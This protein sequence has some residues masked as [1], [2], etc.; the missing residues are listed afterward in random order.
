MLNAQT[1]VVSRPDGRDDLSY[2]PTLTLGDY[3]REVVDGHPLLR[4]VLDFDRSGTR[5]ALEVL[6]ATVTEF[7]TDETGR[8]DSYRLA[9]RD[10]S[11][12]WIGTRQLLGL[13]TGS[14]PADAA[15][16]L[17]ILGGDGLLSRAITQHAEAETAGITLVTGDISA[18]MIVHALAQ[19]LP[20]V[21]QAAEFLF[22]RDESVDAALLA[23]GTHHIAPA[24]RLTAIRE[25]LRVVRPGGRIVLHDFAEDSPMAAFFAEIVHYHTEIG[26]DY[27]HFSR[28]LLDGLFAE[29][30]V[31]TEVLDMYDP[32]VVVGKTEAEA[33]RHMCDYVGA[34]YGVRGLFAELG[35]SGAWALL[36]RI[37][38]HCG[39]LPRLRQN[40][41]FPLAPIVYQRQGEFVAEVPRVALV[42]VGQKVS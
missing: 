31:P 15:V 13:C 3:L 4:S 17:D 26:H 28:E 20:A 9:Q 5:H 36:E 2:L 38:D 18:E 33:R 40:L 25:A 7:D 12:R 37:F 8:G 14:G 32:L 21:R 35:E 27:A 42:A 16:V 6:A 39:Y 10:A 22:L 1:T 34:M 30:S 19:G 41:E 29:T 24:H 23:Y 11:V